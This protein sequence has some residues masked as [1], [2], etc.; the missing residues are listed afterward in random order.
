MS[1]SRRAAGARRAAAVR[2]AA[3]PDVLPALSP[4][5]LDVLDLDGGPS[6]PALA[7]RWPLDAPNAQAAERLDLW[8]VLSRCGFGGSG[9]YSRHALS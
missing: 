8:R 4:R 2:R 9:I 7:V 3:V 1:E 5:Y 6:C